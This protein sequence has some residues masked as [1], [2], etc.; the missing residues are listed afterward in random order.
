MH[1][2]KAVSIFEA[3]TYHGNFVLLVY[4]IFNIFNIIVWCLAFLFAHGSL[5]VV[6]EIL[7]KVNVMS[8]V[9]EKQKINKIIVVC[10]NRNWQSNYMRSQS[11]SRGNSYVT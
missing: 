10:S 11:I 4:K 8:R 1:L 3:M 2:E 6:S 7:E 9:T 5:I